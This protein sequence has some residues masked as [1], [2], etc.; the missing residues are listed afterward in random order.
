MYL[1]P[2]QIAVLEILAVRSRLPTAKGTS[3]HGVDGKS[4][5]SLERCG[6]V[7]TED[8]MPSYAWITV[9]GR[10]A[11]RVIQAKRGVAK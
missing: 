2:K 7:H 8:A 4:V 11:L 9:E 10:E 5:A 6:L 1:R 3:S